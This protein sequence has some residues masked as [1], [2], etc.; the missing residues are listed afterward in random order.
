MTGGF[1]TEVIGTCAFGLKLDTIKNDD[2]DFCWYVKIMFE[3]IKKQIIVQ[4]MMMICPWVIKVL[5]IQMNSSEATNFFYKVFTN[6]IKYRDEHNVIRNNI[7]Q[8]LMQAR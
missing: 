3:N 4:G 2:S 7:T 6:V 8:T 1:S 5:R